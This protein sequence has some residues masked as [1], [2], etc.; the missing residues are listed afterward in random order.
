MRTPGLNQESYNLSQPARRPN[1]YTLQ[2]ER[3][4]EELSTA[5]TQSLPTDQ[6]INQI[7]LTPDIVSNS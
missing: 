4:I 5:C 3:F 1:H 2:T 7:G 6:L